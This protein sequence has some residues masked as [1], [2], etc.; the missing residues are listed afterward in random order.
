MAVLQSLIA[1]RWIGTREG[2]RLASAIDGAAGHHA[3]AEAID[4][5]EALALRAHSGVPGA[6]GARLPAARRAA[7]GARRNT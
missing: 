3:H 7:E 1:D 4:F 5:G 2:A 6:A